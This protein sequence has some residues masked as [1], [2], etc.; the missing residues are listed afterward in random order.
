[1]K[2][3]ETEGVMWMAGFIY[4]IDLILSITAILTLAHRNNMS[5]W[6]SLTLLC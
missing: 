5:W 1:M 4:Q 3:S 6:A 2:V